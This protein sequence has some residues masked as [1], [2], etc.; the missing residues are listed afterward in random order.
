MQDFHAL[1]LGRELALGKGTAICDIE[2]HRPDAHDENLLRELTAMHRC[3]ATLAISE[4]ERCM[5]VKDY[6]MPPNKIFAAP[7]GYPQ[8]LTSMVYYHDRRHVMF[9]GNWRHRPNRD[10]A[11]WLISEVWPRVRERLPDV[12]LHVYGANPSPGDMALANESEGAVVRGYCSDVAKAMISHRLLVAPLRYG[13][14]IKGKLTD[15][16]Y[17]GLVGV[18]TSIGAEG[19]GGRDDFPGVVVDNDENAAEVFAH[20]VVDIYQDAESWSQYQSRART[21]VCKHFNAET[22]N[23]SLQSFISNSQ[24]K[25]EESRRCDFFGNIVWQSMLRSNEWMAKCLGT[26]DELRR[27]KASVSSLQHETA[28]GKG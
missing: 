8:S 27:L 2:A 6:G 23:Q 20:A 19:L 4:E 12:E 14:G 10:C 16:M 3:D 11:Q 26:K 7:L 13:A 24:E 22:N 1:R 15:A 21:Y 17:H 9:I 25:L 5:L 28:T 18:T